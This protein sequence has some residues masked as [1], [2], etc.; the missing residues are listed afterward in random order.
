M[1]KCLNDLV[2]NNKSPVETDD[3]FVAFIL[4]TIRRQNRMFLRMGY[5]CMFILCIASTIDR[6]AR[7]SFCF[8]L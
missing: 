3:L 2:R 8:F 4:I 5:D 7:L 1:K 6:K